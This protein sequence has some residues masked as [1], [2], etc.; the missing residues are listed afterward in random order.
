MLTRT[1]CEEAGPAVWKRPC[2]QT[3][4]KQARS[5]EVKASPGPLSTQV[6]FPSCPGSQAWTPL[7]SLSLPRFLHPHPFGTA[8]PDPLPNLHICPWLFL[9]TWDPHSLS[10]VGLEVVTDPD[11]QAGLA[12]PQDC[13]EERGLEKGEAGLGS[14]GA[15]RTVSC[16]PEAVPTG[17]GKS[18]FF[19]AVSC[20]GGSGL[21]MVGSSR[22]T[23]RKGNSSVV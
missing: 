8:F 1:V 13:W 2:E 6:P 10:Q 14:R 23:V 5:R 18:A 22:N 7:A 9:I 20:Q 17:C 11:L 16:C 21:W 3:E 15:L 4:C 12:A 19:G